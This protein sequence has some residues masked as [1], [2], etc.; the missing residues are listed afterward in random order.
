MTEEISNDRTERVLELTFQQVKAA[1]HRLKHDGPCQNCGSTSW[2]LSSYEGRPNIVNLPIVN[3]EDLAHWAYYLTCR[4]CGAARLV[5]AAYV[6]QDHAK[7]SA[8]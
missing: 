3:T 7:E 2:A 1:I 5:D 8:K 6:A 4:K